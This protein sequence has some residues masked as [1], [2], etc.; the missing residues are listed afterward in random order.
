MRSPVRALSITNNGNKPGNSQ[1]II[2]I[3]STYGL[4][5][6]SQATMDATTGAYL[7]PG[8][9]RNRW[10]GAIVSVTVKATTNDVTG[11]D[12][13]LTGV[14]GTSADWETQGTAGTHTVTAGTTAVW[15]FK[16]LAADWRV[17]I[18]AGATGPSALVV[19]VRVVW[20]ED[21]GN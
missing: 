18:D 3:D 9:F 15:E 20:G 6:G 7:T 19:R 16:P 2:V 12:Q 1:S 8:R 10:D 4:S 5:S 21:Y 11:L 14:A 13:I 17:R